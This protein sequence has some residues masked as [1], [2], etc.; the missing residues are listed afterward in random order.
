MSTTI[1]RPEP[2][3]TF[4]QLIRSFVLPEDGLVPCRPQ[5]LTRRKVAR[6]TSILSWL[7][8]NPYDVRDIH[9]ARNAL[10]TNLKIKSDHML[11]IFSI[12]V[13]GKQPVKRAWRAASIL[14][15]VKREKHLVKF[16]ERIAFSVAEF[17]GAQTCSK[18]LFRQIEPATTSFSLLE[19]RFRL[20]DEYRPGSD[21]AVH[22]FNRL[23]KVPMHLDGVYRRFYEAGGSPEL[24]AHRLLRKVDLMHRR[25][26]RL[27]K[28]SNS[29][30][31]FSRQ[32][33]QNFAVAL[34]RVHT[35][36]AMRIDNLRIGLTDLLLLES[37]GHTY[38]RMMQRGTQPDCSKSGDSAAFHQATLIL[39]HQVSRAFRRYCTPMVRLPKRED[40]RELGAQLARTLI[41][42]G[43]EVSL[44]RL[45]ESLKRKPVSLQKAVFKKLY[46]K[47]GNA[48][49]FSLER[50]HQLFSSVSLYVERRSPQFAHNLLT[51]LIT[52]LDKSVISPDFLL[53]SVVGTLL[54]RRKAPNVVSEALVA[55]VASPEMPIP[56]IENTVLIAFCRGFSASIGNRL[57]ISLLSRKNSVE[58]PG[59]LMM[60]LCSRY[61]ESKEE[62]M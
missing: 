34:L 22:H 38:R 15:S 48:V 21:S 45:F 53:R 42:G 11:R 40:P 10:L 26:M 50:R 1:N 8:T 6:V 58:L 25:Y 18:L 61:G 44:D 29:R 20:L 33:R 56:V 12:A 59:Y 31:N 19:R 39:I 36:V 47:I 35:K 57:V 14:A 54:Y 9:R 23:L 4:D 41:L 37:I 28:A 5:D 27:L 16:Y 51:E 52:G 62:G 24:F 60:G 30:E 55:L 2:T 7:A 32:I 13:Q 43:A 3:V 17:P 46:G 49:H